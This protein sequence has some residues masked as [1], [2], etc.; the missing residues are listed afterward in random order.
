METIQAPLNKNQIEILNL[1]NRELSEQ[2]LLAIKRL[3]VSY[4]ADK[5][6]IMADEIWDKNAWSENYVNELANTHLRTKSSIKKP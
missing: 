2:D 3:I 4:L 5:V 6:S 1:F